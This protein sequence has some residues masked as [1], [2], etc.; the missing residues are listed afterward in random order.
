MSTFSKRISVA[1]V[2]ALSVL[3]VAVPA[4]DAQVANPVYQVPFGVNPYYR[5]RP[6]LTLAQAYYNIAAAGQAL[7]YVPPYAM[8]YNPY[9]VYNP[10]YANP[11]AGAY[12]PYGGYNP[13]MGYASPYTPYGGGY[14][15]GAGAYTPI[16]YG[17][18]A[19]NPYAGYADPYYG[20]LRGVSDVIRAQSQLMLDQERARMLREQAIQ[21]KLETRK[22]QVET[23]LWIKANTPTYSDEQA[24]IAKNILK[25]IQT[26]ATSGEIWSG[27]ALNILLN[28]LANHRAGA[29]TAVGA[30]P[31]EEEVLRHLN[32]SKSGV[33]DLGLLR[34]EGRFTWPAALRDLVEK[35]ERR[36][37]ELQAQQLVSQGASGK[38]DENLLSDLKTNVARLRKDLLAK[39]TDLP[40]T[41]YVE[42]KRF[43]NSFEDALLALEK[44]DAMTYFNF[45]KYVAGGKT[46]QEVANYL[47]ERGLRFAPAVEG[48]EAAYTALHSVLAAYDVAVNTQ[49]VAA[50]E[51]Q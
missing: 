3:G 10:L 33:G 39:G 21:A 35:G 31:V 4:A 7:S 2:A 49:Q 23:D 43:L 32:V 24:R 37:M 22:K 26:H 42:S 46:V 48:D 51:K 28:D 12:S 38:V 15:G 40:T 1:A 18:G 14:G 50:N 16:E 25:R 17:G 9:P 5:V 27:A 45:Q 8:G 47:I 41:Q 36:D 44:G 34:N 6:G 19:Y 20:A 13:Y 30:L 29:K 11:Y